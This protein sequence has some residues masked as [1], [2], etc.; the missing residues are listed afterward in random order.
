MNCDAK[1]Y[2]ITILNI[3]FENSGLSPTSNSCL[4]ITGMILV[5]SRGAVVGFGVSSRLN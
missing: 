5:F 3:A 4:F 2:V 1:C